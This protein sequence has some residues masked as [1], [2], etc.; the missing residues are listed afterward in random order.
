LKKIEKLNELLKSLGSVVIAFSGG[1]DSGVLTKVAF[2]NL[3]DKVLAVTAVSPTYPA[4]DLEEAKRV[5]KEIG[6]RHLIIQTEEF[7][8][9]NFRQNPLNRCYWCKRELFSKLQVIAKKK[10]FKY[11]LDGTNYDDHSDVRPG[12][13]AKKDFSVISPLDEVE[14]TKAQ[15]KDL[16]FSLGLSLW[17]SPSGTCLSSRIPFG[18]EI[19]EDKLTKVEEAEEILKGFFG[20]E[21][22]L[23]ARDHGD[24]LRIELDPKVLASLGDIYE[25]KPLKSLKNLG[26]K[27]ITFDLEGY[28]PAGRR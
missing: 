2:D 24:I 13:Q 14:F 27:Y 17:N 8:D 23:R 9:D 5:A 4:A 16:A 1:L 25:F 28:V 21:V 19:T 15:I 6:V 7:K 22:L 10:G 12:M 3:G 11:V 18:Q 26:Y 20:R